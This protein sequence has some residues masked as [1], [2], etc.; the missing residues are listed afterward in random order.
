MQKYEINIRWTD[1]Y[2]NGVIWLSMVGVI[3]TL[4]SIA[5]FVRKRRL[6]TVS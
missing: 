2:S 3:G 1:F 4:V 5:Y 6:M